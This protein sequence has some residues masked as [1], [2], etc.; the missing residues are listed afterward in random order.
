MAREGD[1]LMGCC[2]GRGV[3][4]RLGVS[5]LK[6]EQQVSTKHQLLC[7]RKPVYNEK[8]VGS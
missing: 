8:N 4:L 5:A 2:A 6:I 7:Q 3:D 1:E